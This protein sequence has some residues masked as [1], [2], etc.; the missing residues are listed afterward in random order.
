MAL[1]GEQPTLFIKKLGGIILFLFGLLLTAFGFRDGST[2]LTAF[3]ILLLAA[4]AVFLALKIMRR[5]Q[6]SPPL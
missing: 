3:G 4:G 5:N 2:G 1:A 6:G